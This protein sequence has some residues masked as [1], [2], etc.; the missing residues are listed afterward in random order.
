[1]NRGMIILDIL[2]FFK[3][4]ACFLI[5]WFLRRIAIAIENLQKDKQ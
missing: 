3:A 4:S 1:M 5:G 2:E